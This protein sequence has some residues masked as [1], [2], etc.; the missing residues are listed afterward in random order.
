MS[1]PKLGGSGVMEMEGRAVSP[2]GELLTAV[3]W[4]RSL[5]LKPGSL[6]E[7]RLGGSSRPRVVSG[8]VLGLSHPR[9]KLCLALTKSRLVSPQTLPRFTVAVSV[10]DG[11]NEPV[12]AGAWAGWL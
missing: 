1:L 7:S 10:F 9:I 11:V 6:W 12:S 4:G 2:G 8:R 5:A 3:L